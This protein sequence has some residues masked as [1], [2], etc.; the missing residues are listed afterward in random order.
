VSQQYLAIAIGNTRGFEAVTERVFQVVGTQLRKS[1]RRRF[2]K[3]LD[4]LLQSGRQV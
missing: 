3:Q 1:R 2:L 4:A